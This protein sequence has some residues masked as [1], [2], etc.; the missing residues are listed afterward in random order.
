MNNDGVIT[1]QD[2][3]ES[4]NTIIG[5]KSTKTLPLG[6]PYAIDLTTLAG[7][8]R[9]IAGTEMTFNS[10]GSA[11]NSNIKEVVAYEYYPYRGDILLL[12]ANQYVIKYYHLVRISEKYIVV[13]EQG[14]KDL[15]CLYSGAIPVGNIT[16]DAAGVSLRIGESR[17]LTAT[18]EPADAI[19]PNVR[20]S[21]SD[22]RIAKVDAEGNI[23]AYG[24]GSCTIT[25]TAIDGSGVSAKCNVIVI[26][27]KNGHESVDLGLSV[28]WAT[29]NIGAT[30]AEDYGD[31]IAWGETEGKTECSWNNY[32]FCGSTFSMSKYC[33]HST[34][35]ILDN[36][37]I[38]E[39]ED[40][41][42]NAIWGGDW[43]MPTYQEFDE[44]INKCT[45][46]WVSN[47]NGFA[48]GY[49]ITSNIPGFTDKTIFLPAA[50][51]NGGGSTNYNI[52]TRGYYWTSSLNSSKSYNA[53]YLYFDYK[54]ESFHAGE[55]YFGQSIR[56]VCP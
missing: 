24:S 16:L 19:V 4:V 10:D 48:P 38:L 37:T 31:C 20:W 17:K 34:Q 50:G 22:E 23:T 44:L 40:D 49:I 45:W 55:R 15:I 35:G 25:A 39:A 26:V 21:S 29:M 7:K 47:Y 8:W 2:V 28:K 42:A 36:K 1:V 51:Y 52:G 32:K 53:N 30:S 41:A 27:A 56:A 9:S 54:E 18:H 46:T 3:T 43:R 5:R 12:D 14:A 33:V 13:C 11:T 6:N